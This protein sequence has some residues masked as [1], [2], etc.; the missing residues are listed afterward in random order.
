MRLFIPSTTRGS[1]SLIENSSP[2]K[3]IPYVMVGNDDKLTITHIGD[4]NIGNNLKLKDVFVMSN[5][6]K[7]LVFVSKLVDDKECSLK[8][9]DK[10]FIVKDKKIRVI[11]A[12]ENSRD[13]LY[14]LEGNPHEILTVLR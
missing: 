10:E 4:N 11:L 3:G 9:T 8:F 7:K 1:T 5:L 13:K 12:K 6:K 14:A 2:F